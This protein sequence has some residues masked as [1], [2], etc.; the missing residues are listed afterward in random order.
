MQ[1]NAIPVFLQ[2]CFFFAKLSKEDNKRGV[3]M[4]RIKKTFSK[5]SN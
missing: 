1:K 3:E 5:V 2:K 4:G